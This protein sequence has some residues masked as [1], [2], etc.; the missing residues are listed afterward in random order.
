[1]NNWWDGMEVWLSYIMTTFLIWNPSFYIN[2]VKKAEIVANE[3]LGESKVL[4][5]RDRE[6]WWWNEDVK[7]VICTVLLSCALLFFIQWCGVSLEISFAEWTCIGL[8][9]SIYSLYMIYG[10]MSL[11]YLAIGSCALFNFWLLYMS[12]RQ[13]MYVFYLS[14]FI[15]NEVLISF[16]LEILGKNMFWL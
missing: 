11:T 12:S 4:D 7:F 14:F 5:Y 13:C 8:L 3:I 2:M 1:M 9:F 10:F 6:T 16:T 15:T